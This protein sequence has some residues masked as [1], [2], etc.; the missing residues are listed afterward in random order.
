MQFL[1]TCLQTRR[2]NP[3]CLGHS[4]CFVVYK[5]NNSICDLSKVWHLFPNPCLNSASYLSCNLELR[6]LQSFSAHNSPNRLFCLPAD[7]PP[8]H[9]SLTLLKE[10]SANLHLN[11]INMCFLSH[12]YVFLLQDNFQSFY[13]NIKCY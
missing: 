5:D 10:I 8:F 12:R 3:E 4:V 2:K 13:H 9:P 7:C 6:K 11:Y 1:L